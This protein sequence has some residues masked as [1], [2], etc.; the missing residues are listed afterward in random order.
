LPNA[1]TVVAVGSGQVSAVQTAMGCH[2]VDCIPCDPPPPNPWLFATCRGGRCIAF[3]AFET[4][5]TSCAVASDCRLRGGL[6]CCETCNPGTDEIVA[7]NASI[8]LEPWL[9]GP[10][11]D[12]CDACTPTPPRLVSAWCEGARCIAVPASPPVD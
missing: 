10:T 5:L 6:G 8:E 2:L 12:E 11:P 7:V 9:C 3:D 1:E 4:E